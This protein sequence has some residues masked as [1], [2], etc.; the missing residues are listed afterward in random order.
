MTAASAQDDAVVIAA[1]T[2]YRQPR[3]ILD[4]GAGDGELLVRIATLRNAHGDRQPAFYGIDVDASGLATAHRRLATTA[5][6]AQ[7]TLLHADATTHPLPRVELACINPPLL[8]GETG[9]V[10][11]NGDLFWQAMLRRLANERFAEVALLHLFGFHSDTGQ[12]GEFRS[13]AATLRAYGLHATVAYA[14]RR[15]ISTTSRI[16]RTLPELAR[17]F[18]R[19]TIY[20][21]GN[22]REL[23]LLPPNAPA[24]LA[25]DHHVYVIGAPAATRAARP[26]TR[27]TATPT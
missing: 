11:A 24:Q 4:I 10:T 26:H 17:V 13:L 7:V 20:V 15:S 18:P 12:H 3:S 9:F 22:A 25:V 8:P 1:C 5:P 6:A 21:D 19:S 14:G 23:Q 16:R 27:Q 2:R